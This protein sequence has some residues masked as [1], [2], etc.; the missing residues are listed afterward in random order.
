MTGL[1]PHRPWVSHTAQQGRLFLPARKTKQQLYLSGCGTLSAF[2][3]QLAI[4]PLAWKLY[5]PW[6][7]Q[8]T[9]EDSQQP[10]MRLCQQSTRRCV[11]SRRG[12]RV[13]SPRGESAALKKIVRTAHD[14]TESAVPEESQQ[15]L[16]TSSK[17]LTIK[18]SPQRQRTVQGDRVSSPR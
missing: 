13:S 2:I 18:S 6:R 5:P 17:Q 8:S 1:A 11:N 7:E 4:L 10:P 12:D 3:S 14:E 16:T 15:P 9:H